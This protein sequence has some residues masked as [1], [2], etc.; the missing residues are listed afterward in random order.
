MKLKIKRSQKEGMMGGVTFALDVLADLTDEEAGLVRRYKLGSSVVYS[1]EAANENFARAQA[2]SASGL[3]ALVMDRLTKRFLT[4][5]NLVSGQHIECKDLVEVITVEEQVRIACQN[6]SG[7]LD[8][9]RTFN[10]TEQI[11]DISASGD[12]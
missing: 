2:G 5:G 7:F 9:A 8:V 6:L 1:S 4:I 11:V 12:A 3:G 10:G